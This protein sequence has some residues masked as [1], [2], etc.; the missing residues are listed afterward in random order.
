MKCQFSEINTHL[1]WHANNKIYE[2]CD[3]FLCHCEA[4]QAYETI[5]NIFLV[6]GIVIGNTI[7][8]DSLFKQIN[9][10]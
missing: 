9:I 10:L 5:L 1:K 2:G 4:C 8:H 6:V 7:S 3:G